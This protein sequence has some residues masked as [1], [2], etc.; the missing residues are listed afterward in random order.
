MTVRPVSWSRSLESTKS[1]QSLIFGPTLWQHSW[2]Y[3][4]DKGKHVSMDVLALEPRFLYLHSSSL[5]FWA[6]PFHFGYC[7]VPSLGNL[8]CCRRG[9]GWS[10]TKM[11]VQRWQY[12]MTVRRG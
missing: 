5:Q 7:I 8:C 12:A 2:Q 3:L 4:P 1:Q 11:Q 6:L 9:R 10:R